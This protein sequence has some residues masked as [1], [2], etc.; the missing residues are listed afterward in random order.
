MKI[1]RSDLTH[2]HEL[3]G[4]VVVIDVLRAFTTAAYAFAAGARSMIAADS[5]DSVA[6]LRRRTP[7]SMTMGALPGG[8]PVPGMDFGNSPAEIAGRDLSGITLIQF[9]AGGVKGLV[10]CD[11]ATEV[12]AGS[13]VCARPTARYIRTLAP[14]T[15]TLVITGLWTDRDGDEDHACADLIEAYLRGQSPD[16]TAYEDR[17]RQ[18]DFGRRFGDS[19]HPHLPAADL[20]LCAAADR[21]GFAMP[22]RRTE[23]GLVIE[24]VALASLPTA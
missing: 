1:L 20:E 23:H 15:V 19:A 22:M 9:T 11:H 21:F 24:P 16:V 14:S 5:L 7:A 3:E 4:A 18:S 17:V 8:R 6:R 13:L 2:G 10:D 12:L